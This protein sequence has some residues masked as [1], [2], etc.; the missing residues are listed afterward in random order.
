M[1]V[2]LPGGQVH[3]SP[4]YSR[5]ALSI[6]GEGASEEIAEELC[7]LFE[8]RTRLVDKEEKK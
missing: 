6:T 8:K 5:S 4:H 3:I 1:H 7:A 2:S